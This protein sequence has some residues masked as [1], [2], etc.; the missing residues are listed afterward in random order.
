MPKID[1]ADVI[2]SLGMQELA[3]NIDAILE[4]ITGQKMGFSL[5]V[6]NAVPGSRMNYISNCNRHE[7]MQA[8]KSLIHGWENGLPDVPAHE[9][10]S[11]THIKIV[12]KEDKS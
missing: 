2:V 9:V 6:F 11:G 1:N 3:K 12:G 8:M 7:V 10:A 5:V 4:E